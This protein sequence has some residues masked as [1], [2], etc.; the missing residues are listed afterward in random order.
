MVTKTNPNETQ[1]SPSRNRIV[2]VYSTRTHQLGCHVEFEIQ[3]L[4][5]FDASPS[6]TLN[7]TLVAYTCI[8]R[9]E[10]GASTGNRLLRK[11]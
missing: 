9:V 1:K 3:S 4:Q 2:W 8:L 10:L 11:V 5:Q 7:K 6:L